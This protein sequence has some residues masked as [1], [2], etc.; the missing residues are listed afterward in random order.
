MELVPDVELN[1]PQS[2]YLPH[3]AAIKET[4]QTT[5]VRVVF[6]ASRLS[7]NKSSLN[8]HLLIGQ[9]LQTDLFS[10][11]LRWRSHQFVYTTDI[12]KM[13]RQIRVHSADVDYQRIFWRDDP[14]LSVY[15]LLTVTYGTASAPFLANRVLKQLARDEGTKFPL[16]APILENEVYVDNVMFGAKDLVILKQ[17]RY[18]L[19]QLLMAGGFRPHKWA[20]TDARLLSDIDEADHGLAVDKYLGGC[21]PQNSW[22]CME[23]LC[24]L[25]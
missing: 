16:A 12:G 3:H 8:D 2:V 15:R 4:S 5:K 9:K 21:Q 23:F 6:N 14:K 7:S 20:S 11:I 1:V 17:A 19:T 10:L 18:Q 22:Y 24:K 13:F 25:I